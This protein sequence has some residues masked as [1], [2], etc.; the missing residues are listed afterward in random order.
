MGLAERAT[1]CVID[2]DAAVRTAMEFLIASHGL[3]VRT[4]ATAEEFLAADPKACGCGDCLV[5]DL[6]MPGVN[7]AELQ[8]RLDREGHGLPVVVLTARPHDE[9]SRRAVAAGARTI[10]SK[11]VD[12]QHLMT[13]IRAAL[14]GTTG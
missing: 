3:R 12:P 2:D 10:V 4:F 5:L 8:E 7:G 11:P 13:E 14:A 9:L 1:V 6:H